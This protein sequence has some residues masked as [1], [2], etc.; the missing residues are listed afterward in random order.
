MV[1]ITFL[2]GAVPRE[3]KYSCNESRPVAKPGGVCGT[4]VQDDI[5][6]KRQNTPQLCYGDEWRVEDG[7]AEAAS[8]SKKTAGCRP[9]N[10]SKLCFE[11]R[12][13]GLFYCYEK[14]NL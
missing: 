4:G 6:G 8:L 7:A 5:I 1:H 2:T 11:D 9:P 13:G 14:V 10:T 12:T 3:I